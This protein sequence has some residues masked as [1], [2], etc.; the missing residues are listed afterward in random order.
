MENRYMYHYTKFDSFLK[1]WKSKT[2]RFPSSSGLNDMNEVSKFY[3]AEHGPSGFTDTEPLEK[4]VELY[5]RISLT[6]EVESSKRTPFTTECGNFKKSKFELLKA[7]KKYSYYYW[8]L[9]NAS[10]IEEFDRQYNDGY[11]KLFDHYLQ[12]LKHFQRN[13]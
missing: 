4:E 7:K 6:K 2:L 12:V 3:W 10:R 11:S 5:K 9:Q 8:A 1:I 13:E